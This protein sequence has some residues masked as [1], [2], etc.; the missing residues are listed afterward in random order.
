MILPVAHRFRIYS[1]FLIDLSEESSSDSLT[2]IYFAKA[3][4]SSWPNCSSKGALADRDSLVL[5]KEHSPLRW[6]HLFHQSLP[7]W[8]NLLKIF[9]GSLHISLATPEVIPSWLNFVEDFLS[10]DLFVYCSPHLRS[11]KWGL[12]KI[13]VQEFSGQ[14]HFLWVIQVGAFQDLS[15]GVFRTIH[16]F[17]VIFGGILFFRL[18]M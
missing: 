12:S 7:S 5:I 1:E 10:S 2:A 17:W 18:L 14:F 11:S 4:S 8:L 6:L 15:T 16:V 9:F 3:L 13:W